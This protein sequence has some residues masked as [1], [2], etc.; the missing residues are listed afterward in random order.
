MKWV[1]F[2]GSVDDTIVGAPGLYHWFEHIPFR[3]TKK[4]PG[5]QRDLFAKLNRM[6]GSLNAHTTEMTTVYEVIIPFREWRHGLEL[7]T[8]LAAQPLLREEDVEKERKIIFQ[9]IV[10]H[11]STVDSYVHSKTLNILAH[12]HPFGHHV[13]GDEATLNSMSAEMLVS[14]HRLGY[15][16]CRMAL[17]VC[18]GMSES[19]LVEEVLSLSDTLPQ[20]KLTARTCGVYRGD[21]PQ[22]PATDV[23]VDIPFTESVTSVLFPR[24]GATTY[25]ESVI[26]SIANSMF[27]DGGLSSPLMRI[28]REDRN[29]VYEA[30]VNSDNYLGGG[31]TGFK[32]KSKKENISLIMQAFRDVLDDPETRSIERFELIK[33][34][35]QGEIELQPFNPDVKTGECEC[36]LL[37][38]FGVHSDDEYFE[39][40][41]SVVFEEVLEAM[42]VFNPDKMRTIIFKGIG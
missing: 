40:L 3:G 35:I 17:V 9:E 14:A 41:K 37:N 23:T 25:R 34:G 32:A 10:S 12:N 15:D 39:C 30:C 4:F 18:G 28:L 22:W 42:K 31:Y 26:A 29:L 24:A 6:G 38:P 5:G 33:E 2:V 13:L 8:D 27:G 21:L 1:V 7:I 16:R 11:T 20:N 19:E 36:Q